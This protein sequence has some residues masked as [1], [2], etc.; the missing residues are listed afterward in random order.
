[1]LKLKIIQWLFCGFVI[2]SPLL[3]SQS[4]LPAVS[5]DALA[6]G[7]YADIP[8]NGYTGTADVTV[9]LH[10]IT[11]G[12]L[13][14]AVYLQYHTAGQLVAAP[15]SDVGLGWNLNTGGMISR[16][17]RGEPDDYTASGYYH[18]GASLHYP[19]LDDPND[20]AWGWDSQPDI[21]TYSFGGYVGKFFIDANQKVQTVPKS[22]IKIEPIE[23]YHA[24]DNHAFQ[25]IIITTPEGVKYKFGETSNQTSKAYDYAAYREHINP[26]EHRTAWYL[27]EIESADQKHRINIEYHDGIGYDYQTASV[28][29]EEIKY[30]KNDDNIG[31]KNACG[32]SLVELYHVRTALPKRITT[33]NASESVE[34]TISSRDDLTRYT[35]GSTTYNPSRIDAMRVQNGSVCTKWTFQH[36]Y[37][38]NSASASAAKRLKL[39]GIQRA[40]CDGTLSEPAWKFTYQGSTNSDASMFFPATTDKNIDHWGYYNK[41]ANGTDNNTFGDITPPTSILVGN[42]YTQYGSANRTSAEVPMLQGNLQRVTYPTGGYLAVELEANKYRKP[43]TTTTALDLSPCSSGCTGVGSPVEGTFTLTQA[44]LD[45][46]GRW[47]LLV[48]AEPGV[49]SGQFSGRVEVRTTGGSYV[50]QV[51]INDNYSLGGS[52]PRISYSAS[53]QSM[54]VGQTYKIRVYYTNARV[55][56]T[57][58][59]DQ[60][61]GDQICGGLRLKQTK[62]HDGLATANDIITSYK[63]GQKSD[64]TK[65]SGKLHRTPKYGYSLNYRTAVFTAYSMTPLTTFAGYH[66]AYERVVIDK[67][68]L[69]QEEL[70][71]N[72]ETETYNSDEYPIRPANFKVLE[73]VVKEGFSY[74]QGSTQFLTKSTATK[75]ASDGYTTFGNSTP[76]GFIFAARSLSVYENGSVRTR[77]FYT[78]YTLRTGIYRVA[79]VTSVVDGLTT[80]TNYTY[81]SNLLIPIETSVTNSNGDVAK[82]KVTYT[83]DYYDAGF[84]AKFL[85]YNMLYVPYKTEGYINSVNISGQET[86][87]RYYTSA[88]KD[89]STSTS[90]RLDLPRPYQQWQLEK[91]YAVACWSEVGST[92]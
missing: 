53:D 22:D 31:T 64:A 87:F 26:A 33:L 10:T 80:E 90:G 52:L 2:L 61:Q 44:M 7:K 71:Y 39:D 66:I 17:V 91:S 54:V 18:K 58:Q 45:G 73:G 41:V 65:S 86:S 32:G 37:F 5:A 21:F 34:F 60:E 78:P 35:V 81:G 30:R 92:P 49:P 11:D 28:C 72:Y 82:T 77:N 68:G 59:Y 70:I 13:S 14:L 79:K 42:Q 27:V 15:A 6:Y 29:P 1:M 76:T 84:R 75:V 36:S 43:T 63:Y 74:A 88:G 85:K 3:H 57:I 40:A 55:Q 51:E 25:Q 4:A 20:P 62:V 16:T 50:S 9:P 47:T 56:F 12:P 46:N 8:V 48:T 89:P 24:S 83:G 23:P 38:K 67:N 69:G 19:D